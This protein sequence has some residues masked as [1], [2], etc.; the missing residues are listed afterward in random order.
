L[1]IL[2]ILVHIVN[3]IPLQNLKRDGLTNPDEAIDKFLTYMPEEIGIF[4]NPHEVLEHTSKLVRS[5]IK[6]PR[7]KKFLCAD[8]SSIE[9]VAVPWVTGEKDLVKSFADGLDMYK[10]AAAR[11]YHTTYEE[12]TKEQRQ[13]GK[14]AVLACG[15][16]GGYRALM[17][18]A[19]N[20]GIKITEG[21]A[22]DQ[23]R[24][25]RNS[26]PLLTR[27]WD[28]FTAAMSELA[29][30]PN[31]PVKVKC[32]VPIIMGSFNIKGHRCFYIE[33]PSG[34]RLHY[35]FARI[36]QRDWALTLR[37]CIHGIFKDFTGANLFQNV[38]QAICRDLL[39]H[40]QLRLEEEGYPIIMTV[41][42]EL[43]SMVPDEDFYR[44]EDFIRIMTDKPAWARTLP[45]KADGW[46]GR[47]YR[48]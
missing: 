9:A 22:Q 27:T 35:P 1:E 21:E 17:G 18:M 12:V 3:L 40:A 23:V 14:I 19:A 26:R 10:V 31:K 8:F 29:K 45:V 48:K 44:L 16:A 33:L 36:R 28:A 11:M 43:I 25:F 13:A 7:G 34:R 42:D 32:A 20:Y 41:H 2:N 30:A 4:L 15:Y 47:R 46:Q 39:T 38:V 5:I 37:A 24:K 6:A